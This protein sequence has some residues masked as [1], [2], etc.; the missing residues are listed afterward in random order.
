MKVNIRKLAELTGYSPATISNA[1]NHKRGVNEKTAALIINAAW[2]HG[3]INDSDITKIK[4]VMYKENGLIVEDTPFFSLVIDGFEKE[5]H[6]SGM[7]MIM[8][9][10][11]HGKETYPNELHNL[12]MD[13]SAGVV[14]LGSEISDSE[15]RHFNSLKVPFLTL[16][17]WIYDMSYDGVFIN[18]ADSARL[19]V[20]YL[21]D[22]GH[23]KIG[24]IASD[25]RINA[26]KERRT[27]LETGL[28][29]HGLSLQEKYLIALH[30]TMDGAYRGM[31]EYLKN[32]PELPSAY[33]ADNDIL[34]LSAMKALQESGIRVPE[35]V[36]IIGF[37]DLPFCEI[38]SPRLTSIR[39]PK[40]EMGAAAAKRMIEMIHTNSRTKAKIQICTTL[41]ERD[42]VMT[43]ISKD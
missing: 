34:A 32:R 19:A 1:I 28:K 26:F 2:D 37:D 9:H 40:Q 18:N 16:E 14:L 36:S 31:M 15:I 10:L 7:E 35:E 42:S 39:V 17:Y 21:I 22:K 27:G 20:E 5:C 33:F 6:Q 38:S 8:C 30:P 4:F 29:K 3:Y 23:R 13:T 11:N 24:Y 41:I 43:R 25:H 12:L